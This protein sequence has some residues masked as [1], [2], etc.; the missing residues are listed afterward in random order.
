MIFTS[1]KNA[2]VL[3]VAKVLRAGENNEEMDFFIMNPKKCYK[4]PVMR[5]HICHYLNYFEAFFDTEKEYFT[6]LAHI[7]FLI[8]CVHCLIN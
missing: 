3:P 6:N 4:S 1:T 8:D 7:K 5:E 2:I